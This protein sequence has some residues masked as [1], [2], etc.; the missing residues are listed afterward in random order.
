M[1]NAS[2]VIYNDQDLT[3]TV[4][5]SLLGISGVMGVTKRGP[6]GDTSIVITRWE[7][8]LK[9]YGG[10]LTTSD[11][12]LLCKRTLDRGGKLRVSRIAHYTD[13]TDSATITAL[14]PGV[15]TLKDTTTIA[16][17]LFSITPK[18]H[19]VDYNKL[20]FQVLAP[21][22]GLAA[23]GFFDVKIYISDDLTNTLEHYKNLQIVGKPTIETSTYLKDIIANSALVNVTY[24][25]LSAATGVLLPATI[26]KAFIGGSDG[27]AIVPLDYIGAA[28]GGTGFHAF[29]TQ[30]D[31]FQIATP[32]ISDVDVINAGSAYAESRQDLQY[33]A[34]LDETLTSHTALITLRALV[35]STK[36][37]AFFGGGIKVKHPIDGTTHDISEMGDVLGAAAYVDSKFGPW[38]SIANYVRAFIPNAI[39]VVKNF[40]SGGDYTYL[41]LL[42][43]RQIN[44]MV[45][46]NNKVYIAGNYS[47]QVES[48]A[49]SFNNIVRLLIFIKKSLRPTLTKYLE[50]PNDLVT[51][52]ALY[53][54]VQ[55]FLDEL[56][57]KRALHKEANGEPGYRWEGDQDADSLDNLNTNTAAGLDAGK[58]KVRLFLKPINSIN[59]IEIAIALSPSGVSFQ[60]TEQLN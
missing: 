25:D 23:S 29:N 59:E 50:E 16:L 52:R 12:P 13:V 31:M 32:E 43:N 60:V 9:L 26:I 34:H 20:K 39:G 2:R 40:G 33:F 24:A 54:E 14:K 19:G 56:V 44:M 5:S 6:V 48:S 7:E 28:T 15:Q 42:A 57:D 51:F 30:D 27:A 41:N 21:S 37:T 47:G 35:N 53:R 10:L 58:Y 22:N 45:A 49:A 1:P 11:F 4:N 46:A 38:Y 17:T 18:Y 36:Y 8:F 55:P 3:P